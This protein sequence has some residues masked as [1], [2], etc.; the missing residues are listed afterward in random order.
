MNARLLDAAAQI[1]VLG[2]LKLQN[3]A[4]PELRA[5]FLISRPARR[6]AKRYRALRPLHGFCA[7][8]DPDH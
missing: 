3:A 4:R 8:P 7:I 5:G 6:P 1:R 2:K